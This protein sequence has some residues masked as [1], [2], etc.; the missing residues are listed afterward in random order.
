[1]DWITHDWWWETFLFK[2]GNPF[3]NKQQFNLEWGIKW[4]ITLKNC[5]C[6][7]Y[8]REKKELPSE[9]KGVLKKVEEK[10]KFRCQLENRY[11][12]GLL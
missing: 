1:M 10:L 4:K 11:W 3:L 9:E 8:Y 2:T 12:Q 7:S 5:E 6:K